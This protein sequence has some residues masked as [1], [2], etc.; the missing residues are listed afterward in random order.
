[1]PP[2][3]EKTGLSAF[4]WNARRYCGGTDG[5]SPSDRSVRSAKTDRATAA[6]ASPIRLAP[7]ERRICCACRASVINPTDSSRNPRHDEH[8]RLE[9]SHIGD[10]T[11]R[12]RNA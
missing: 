4:F 3:D 11:I 2:R 1:L 5:A 9:Y 6:G 7:P 12:L 10:V 8:A